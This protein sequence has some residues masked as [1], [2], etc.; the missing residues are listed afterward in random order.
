MIGHFGE[1]TSLTGPV[2]VVHCTAVDHGSYDLLHLLLMV[3]AVLIWKS[4]L[5][6]PLSVKQCVQ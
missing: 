2:V 3:V 5:H 1:L 6:K 4:L